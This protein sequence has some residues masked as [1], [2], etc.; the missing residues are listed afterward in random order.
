MKNPY[1]LLEVSE[2]A[3]VDEIKKSYRKKAKQY[4]PDLN[5]GNEE[6]AEKFKELSE[7]YAIL[8]DEEKRRTYDTYGAAAF[9]NGGMGAGGFDMGGF[10]DLFDLFDI[11]GGGRRRA[12]PNA[13]RQGEDIHYELVISFKEAVFGTEKTINVPIQQA[14]SHCHGHGTADGKRPETCPTCGGSGEVQERT[15]SGF[16]S[17]VRSR[18]CPTCQGR[19]VLIKEK[20]SHC[21]GRGR[22]KVEKTVKITVPEGVNDG[23]M[24]PIRGYGHQGKNGGPNGDLYVVFKVRPS[25]L[26]VRRDNDLFFEL[27][28]TYAQVVLGDTVNI[29]TLE[30]EMPFDIPAGTQPGTRFKLKDKGVKDVHTKR[31][32]N[33]YF[34][35]LVEVPE[36]LNEDQKE[37]LRA[38]SRSMGEN[39]TGKKKTFF[40]KVRDLFD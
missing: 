7:A 2:Q 37:A 25:E 22:E 31:K 35:V 33:L 17:F 28:L 8:S 6:A 4:H 18:Q 23:N 26:F 40:D 34:D 27:P 16:M 19:G 9:E 36:N 38:F 21:K 3:T 29:P 24:M 32:G 14:C 11:F 39:P 1:E 20:C 10:G 13:P 5:P 15:Q 12:N 30:G